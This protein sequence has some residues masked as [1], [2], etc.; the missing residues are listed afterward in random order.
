MLSS[1]AALSGAY[2]LNLFGPPAHVREISVKLPAACR[3]C[4]C[5]VAI[6]GPGAG[7]HAASVR[8]RS[9]GR[10]VGWLS[11]A[12]CAYINRV[13]ETRGLQREPIVLPAIHTSKP[14]PGPSDTG[15]NVVHHNM[16]ED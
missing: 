1:S 14:K 7:P 3:H 2:Q 16:E 4:G 11:R 5:P 9:C 15:H 10:R 13:L 6:V 8:C 12:H